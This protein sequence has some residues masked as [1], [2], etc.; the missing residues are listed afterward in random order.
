MAFTM[1]KDLTIILLL[2]FIVMCGAVLFKSYSKSPAPTLIGQNPGTSVI[3]EEGEVSLRLGETAT[4]RNLTL[5]PVSVVEDSRCAEGVQ[6]IQAG[7]VRVNTEIIS[8]LGMSG[9]TIEA[10][11]SVTTEA[12][13]ITLISVTPYP[14]AGTAIRSD[15]YRFVYRVE[16]RP[17]GEIN[18][19][20]ST[21]KCYIGGCSGQICSDQPGM[22]STCE[23]RE[24]YACYKTAKCER[25]ASGLCGWTQ[26]AELKMCLQNAN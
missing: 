9:M 1:K 10:G 8:G 24:A 6:C 7:R 11:K 3:P 21:E 13:K 20:A 18:P 16:K 5:T 26:T 25:Q 17:A 15:D 23:Y 22:A 2:A 19:G 4:F 12:Q 14:K